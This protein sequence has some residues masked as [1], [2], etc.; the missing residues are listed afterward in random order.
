MSRL[1]P[2]EQLDPIYISQE[3]KAVP[4]KEENQ[5]LLHKEPS[6]IVNK[7]RTR[8]KTRTKTRTRTKTKTRKK[9]VAASTAIA[10]S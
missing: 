8:T 6:I 5:H 7:A 2:K 3:S 4:I 10:K 9:I 1:C